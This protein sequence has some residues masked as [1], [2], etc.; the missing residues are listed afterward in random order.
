MVQI[1]NAFRNVY[2]PSL[3]TSHDLRVYPPVYLSS[4]VFFIY[5]S[6]KVLQNVLFSLDLGKT[7]GMPSQATGVILLVDF[8]SEEYEVLNKRMSTS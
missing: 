8:L 1:R 7:W 3:Q 2:T 4:C 5:A 6:E